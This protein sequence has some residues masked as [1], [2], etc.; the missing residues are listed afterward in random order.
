M[1]TAF[2]INSKSFFLKS[3]LGICTLI[4]L[5]VHQLNSFHRATNT[6]AI[7]SHH[8]TLSRA[9]VNYRHL[10]GEKVHEVT[11]AITKGNFQD[12]HI[13][14]DE[15]GVDL[16]L[17]VGEALKERS[18][19]SLE[20]DISKFREKNP[21]DKDGKKK[22]IAICAIIRNEAKNLEEW[23]AFHYLQGAGK[24]IIYDDASMDNPRAVLDK[25]IKLG[26]VDF[27]HISSDYDL[28]GTED[29]QF[30]KMNECLNLVTT[31][32]QSEGLRF[33]LFPDLD[34]F[35]YPV[36]DNL[37]LSDV[38]NRDHDREPCL[39]LP[40]TYYGTSLKHRT[41][42]S[43]LIIENY[44]MRSPIGDDGFPKV[45]VHLDPSYSGKKHSGIPPFIF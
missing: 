40:R 18:R 19:K 14:E 37:T 22:D 10:T 13:S 24:I 45:I 12:Y 20:C 7:L 26:L 38:L 31:I 2:R 30:E 16:L 44:F 32:R 1:V 28:S 36:Q 33:V 25:Y 29:L 21:W 17:R 43:G 6:Y 15:K 23:I 8:D 34:E 35:I 3:A 39:I 42:N 9:T 11:G 27:I 4:G 41:P 5:T